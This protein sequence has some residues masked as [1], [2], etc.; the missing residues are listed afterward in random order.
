MDAAGRPARPGDG[1]AWFAKMD[2]NRDGDLSPREFIGP[3]E[4]FRRL[5]VDGDG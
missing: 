4:V 5:D 1:P 3:R 2:R